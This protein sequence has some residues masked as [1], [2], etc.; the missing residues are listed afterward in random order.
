MHCLSRWVMTDEQANGS[1][2]QRASRALA[3]S[4]LNTVVSRL[5]TLAIGIVL[6]RVLGP[7]EFGV[8]AIAT[9]TMLAV[10]SF[11][12]LGVSLAIV[13]WPD[14]PA[15]IA[16]T[17][18][19]ISV[20]SSALLTLGVVVSAPW[21]S[22]ALG[23]VRATPVVQL[24]ACAI[25]INGLVATP[26]AL[27]QREFMQRERTI[28]DQVNAWLGAFVSLGLALMGWGAMSLAVGRIAGS[29]VAGVLFWRWSPLPYRFGWD[30]SVA[31]RLLGFGLPLAAASIVV[32]ASG[33]A[34]QV[35]VGSM[36]GAQALGF[37]VLAF[38]L[39]SWP[40]S[41]FSLP[42]RAVAPAAF[43]KI[44]S[45][46]P[47]MTRAFTKVLGLLSM[48]AV[49]ACLAISG[50]ARPVIE[51]VYGPQWAPA[52]D[53]LLWLA[54]VA[55]LRIWFELCYDFLVVL[56]RSGVVLVTQSLWFASAVPLMIFGVT[57]AGAAGAAAGQFAAAAIV[58]VP[59]YLIVLRSAGIRPLSTARAVAVPTAVG[60]LLW[61]VCF[62]ISVMV[63]SVA[64]A[65]IGA[66]VVT[67]IVLGGMAYAKRGE[68]KNLRSA[69][70]E[71][72]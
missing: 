6:A 30:R 33:Y 8:F 12:E 21:V 34:D 13:R 7:S 38:N 56:G 4:F 53:I 31:R 68:L 60:V 58:V 24:M 32:F 71:A 70:T 5:G 29:L 37:Y 16:P 43:A 46:P 59:S 3:W 11:N 1:V 61:G 54:L 51:F 64:L 18:N 23:D 42:L 26:A 55:A 48:V 36:L 63:D 20:I 44:Q 40:V 57:H 65:S 25:L 10:L 49:P 69:R 17:V 67:L 50:A 2:A 66:G 19:L 28:A 35:I 41:I 14:D 47:R 52:A 45:D 39:A 22:T 9:V 62:G 15:D 27:L 72:T